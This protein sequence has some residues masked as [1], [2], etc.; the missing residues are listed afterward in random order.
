MKLKSKICFITFKSFNLLDL[1][2]KSGV[3]NHLKALFL[4]LLIK[5]CSSNEEALMYILYLF[6]VVAFYSVNNKTF[7]IYLFSVL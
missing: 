7:T 6:I 4:V 3:H 5:Q 1:A 2:L